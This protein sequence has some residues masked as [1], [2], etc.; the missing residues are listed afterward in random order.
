MTNLERELK[1][2]DI[3][4]LTK[5]YRLKAIAFPVVM[6]RCASWI[7]KKAEL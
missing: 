2:S 4:L 5:V 7:M 1:S 3:T 6:Y